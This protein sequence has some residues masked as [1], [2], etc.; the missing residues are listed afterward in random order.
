MQSDTPRR[1]YPRRFGEYVDQGGAAPHRPE[2]NTFRTYKRVPFGSHATCHYPYL[3]V[4]EL[5]I[6]FSR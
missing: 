4:A 3:V 5:R 2:P 1:M 6:G